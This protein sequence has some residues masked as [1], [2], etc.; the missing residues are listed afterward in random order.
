MLYLDDVVRE[1]I[2]DKGFDVEVEYDYIYN[3]AVRGLQD[4][5]Y[6]VNGVPKYCS[7]TP[8]TNG[9]IDLPSDYMT[10]IYIG[11]INANGELINFGFNSELAYIEGVDEDGNPQRFTQSENS[12]A[13][14]GSTGSLRT[15]HYNRHGEAIGRFYGYGGRVSI[16][17]YNINERLGKIYLSTNSQT[18]GI[19]LAYLSDLSADGDDYLVHPMALEPLLNYLEWTTQRMKKSIPAGEKER[20][21]MEYYRTKRNYKIQKMAF[22]GQVQQQFTRK[23][24][25]SIKF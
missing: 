14:Y 13:F 22:N 2:A 25:K 1:Y 15:S 3:K 7:A 18:S 5:W 20:L 9:I 17:E 16:G 6:D 4:L 24:A 12:T 23:S 11:V 10:L 21:K 8:D 19:V